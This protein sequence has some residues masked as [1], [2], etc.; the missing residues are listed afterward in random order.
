MQLRSNFPP[1]KCSI[2]SLSKYHFKKGRHLTRITSVF[3]EVRDAVHTTTSVS[4][5]LPLAIQSA[6]GTGACSLFPAGRFPLVYSN[7][8]IYRC[9]RTPQAE[10][11]SEFCRVQVRSGRAALLSQPLGYPQAIFLLGALLH[12]SCFSHWRREQ[13]PRG[14]WVWA[15]GEQQLRPPGAGRVQTAGSR[16]AERS[17]WGERVWAQPS[18]PAGEHLPG[19]PG[20]WWLLYIHT[21]QLLWN[22]L[23]HWDGQWRRS[24]DGPWGSDGTG[25]WFARSEEGPLL[26]CFPAT[27]SL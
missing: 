24:P 15:L 6:A 22:Q 27:H 23:D 8:A 16:S 13:I 11:T 4:V 21:L 12:T 18:R 14:G 9:L 17:S 1:I 5:C 3:W 19:C 26:I 7:A 10:P 20:V 2:K 25:R